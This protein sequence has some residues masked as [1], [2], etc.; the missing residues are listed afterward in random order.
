MKIK[1][2]SKDGCE[3]CE[4]AK[5]KLDKMGYEYEEHT[6]SYHVNPHYNWRINGSRELL[7]WAADKGDP[8]TQLPTIEINGE[9]YTYPEAMKEL[10]RK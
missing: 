10:K 2:Y 9:Y 1:I 8:S 5:D 4:A 7:A 6:L 3:K